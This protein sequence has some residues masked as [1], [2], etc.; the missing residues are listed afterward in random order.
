LRYRQRKERKALMNKAV[1]LR[2]SVSTKSGKVHPKGSLWRIISGSGPH[3]MVR[4]V[5]EDG[6]WTEEDQYISNLERG[7]FDSDDQVPPTPKSP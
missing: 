6:S 2:R 7:D 1:R 5:N 4:S 3:F